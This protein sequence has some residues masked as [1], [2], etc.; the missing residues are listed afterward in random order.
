MAKN[1]DKETIV[2]FLTTTFEDDFNIT[3][4]ERFEFT[5]ADGTY[6]FFTAD[7][8]VC[9][10][11]D[12]DTEYLIEIVFMD[13]Q[14][15]LDYLEDFTDYVLHDVEKAETV[16]IYNINPKIDGVEFLKAAAKRWA[17]GAAMTD[18]MYSYM[19]AAN[20]NDKDFEYI[21]EFAKEMQQKQDYL[22]E[23]KSDKAMPIKQA[24]LIEKASIIVGY[25]CVFN[26]DDGAYWHDEN[27]KETGIDDWDLWIN[28]EEEEFTINERLSFA[29]YNALVGLSYL[30]YFK[31][32]RHTNEE[33]PTD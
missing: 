16:F 8:L 13:N 6:V 28:W 33:P 26:T 10:A 15:E 2:E 31:N 24:Q 14:L 5:A 3:T 17:K 12:D 23:M 25:P 32:W 30:N 22:K 18:E 21:G 19:I 9:S 29:Q 11:N 7:A 20:A 27:L 4:N 1:I